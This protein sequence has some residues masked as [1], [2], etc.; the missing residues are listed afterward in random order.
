MP[1]FVKCVEPIVSRSCGQAPINVLKALSSQNVCPVETTTTAIAAAAAAATPPPEP[2]CNAEKHKAFDACWSSFRNNYTFEPIT[3]IRNLK[4]E[5][6]ETASE[7]LDVE[8]V[9]LFL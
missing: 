8:K 1:K 7:E 5:N 2:E 4:E 3:L 6:L 9:L